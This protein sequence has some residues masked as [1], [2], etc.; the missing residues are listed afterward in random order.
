MPQIN[1]EEVTERAWEL[2]WPLMEQAQTTGVAKRSVGCM[3]VVARMGRNETV[4]RLMTQ[5][6]GDPSAWELPYDLI[7]DSKLTVSIKT[8]LPSREVQEARRIA[9]GGYPHWG[10]W[11]S[12]IG[13]MGYSIEV[14]V[15]FSGVDP[16]IDELYCKLMVDIM[17]SLIELD[18]K[19]ARL[20]GDHSPVQYLEFTG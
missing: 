3:L 14:I 10:S 12:F 15:A 16:E 11:V 8:G 19:R 1:L 7:A 18:V 9:I 6:L 13:R 2:L 5:K 4:T 20:T 17:H